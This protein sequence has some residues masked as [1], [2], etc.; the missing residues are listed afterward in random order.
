MSKEEFFAKIDRALEEVR[1]GK[2]MLF[3]SSQELR[4][5]YDSL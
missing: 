5:Y 1:A 4:S 2:G 3:N